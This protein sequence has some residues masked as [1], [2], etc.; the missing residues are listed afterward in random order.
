MF[1]GFIFPHHLLRGENRACHL[2][3]NVEA[4]IDTGVSAGVGEVE[5]DE[6]GDGASETFLRVTTRELRH[7]FKIGLGGG[8]DE[9]HEVVHRAAGAAQG[10]LHV[11]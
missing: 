6:H 9:C 3:G 1:D 2:V 5:R 10:C 8:G 4:A 11:G 7:L